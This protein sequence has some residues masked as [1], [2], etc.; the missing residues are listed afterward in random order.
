MNVVYEPK[1]R[2]G[3]YSELACNLYIGCSHGCGYCYAPACMRKTA[4]DYLQNRPRK[5]VIQLLEKD[6]QKLQGDTRQILF[7][8]IS[9][10][11]QPIERKYRLTRQALEIMGRYHLRHKVLTKGA[12]DLVSEDFDLMML[13]GTQLGV[14][15]VYTDDSLRKAWEPN[16]SS[17]EERLRILKEAHKLGIPTWVSVEPVIYPAQALE[18]I[19][20]AHEYVDFWAVSKLNYDLARENSVHWVVFLDRVVSCLKH[21]NCVYYIKKDLRKFGSMEK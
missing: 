4:K 8:F 17:V 11:Y 9:D 6:A 13:S 14:S 2:A 18:L 16:A 12:Y 20:V 21:F 3:E 1:G 5:D 15:L 7:S 19:E 10:P